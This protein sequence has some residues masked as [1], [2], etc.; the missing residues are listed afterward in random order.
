MRRITAALAALLAFMLVA[1]PVAGLA[2]RQATLKAA[3]AINFAEFS[4]GIGASS[5]TIGGAESFIKS[6]DQS[7]GTANGE[8]DRFWSGTGSA[9]TTPTSLDL[10]G[11]LTSNVASGATTSFAEVEMLIVENTSAS[12]N[13]LV[14]GGATPFGFLTVGTTDTLKIPPG[15]WVVIYLGDA[16]LTATGGSTDLLWLTSSTGTVVFKVWVAGR[17]A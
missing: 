10:V 6:L 4:T 15:G 5:A 9:T 13:L 1:L 3:V 14:G 8:V 11:S 16:G 2:A 17:S 7:S 12:G